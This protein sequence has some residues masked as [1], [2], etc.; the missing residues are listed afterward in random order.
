VHSEPLVRFTGQRYGTLR[1]ETGGPLNALDKLDEQDHPAALRRTGRLYLDGT[2]V[3]PIANAPLGLAVDIGTT[4]VVVRLVDLEQRTVLV[5]SAFE[6]PQRRWGADV[7]SRI[8][9]E[10]ESPGRPLQ[11]AIV[12]ALRR[13][14]ESFPCQ[15][16]KIAEVVVAGNTV[17]RDILFGLDVAPI[18]RRPYLSV[19]ESTWRAGERPDTTVT[20]RADTLGFSLHPG[21]RIVGLPLIASHVG[22]D[23][24]A[25]L[26][27]LDLLEGDGPSALIDFGSNTEILVRSGDRL[28]AASCP[29]GPAFEGGGVRCGMPAFDGAVEHVAID[30]AEEPHLTVIGDDPPQGICGSGLIDLLSELLRRGLV[31]DRG[32]FPAGSGAF[33]LADDPELALTERDVAALL[34]AKAANISGALLTFAESGVADTAFEQVYLAGGF[35]SHIDLE[36]AR[37]I[38]FLPELPLELYRKVGNAAIEGATL[39]LCSVE[40]RA[41]LN[42]FVQTAEHLQL[43][44]HPRFFESFVE[45]CLLRSAA[46]G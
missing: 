36:A 37:S 18:G 44:A 30:E 42:G 26:L 24:A 9:V 7:I 45:G 17:M 33:Q 40:R 2:D 28:L 13:A 1:I 10:S 27:A 39:A 41:K 3:G 32:R 20:A 35:I 23:A 14:I 4:T 38:G 8:Q 6:N 12:S 46:P 29:A 31:N 43:E 21:A 16:Q 34:Q 15:P 22:A 25:A 11:Y 19:I 5:S